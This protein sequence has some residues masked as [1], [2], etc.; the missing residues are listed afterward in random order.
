[1]ADHP[2][3]AAKV[4]IGWDPRETGAYSVA[5]DSLL[6]NSSIP[7]AVTPLQLSRLELG[8]LVRRPR[9]ML[10]KGRQ[11]RVTD[12]R[13]ERRW[14]T[15]AQ[16][17]T[18]IDEISDAPMSTEFACSRFIVPLL[19]QSGWALFVDCDVLFLAD[20]R[21][22]FALADD[23]F[24]VMVVQHGELAG[25]GFKM[26]G[27]P[28]VPYRRKNWSSVMLF[29]CDHPANRRLTLDVV[30]AVPGRDL[31]AFAWLDA[32]LI[33]ALPGEWNWLVGVQPRPASPKLAH[34]TLGGPWL[35]SWKGAEHDD[36]WLSAAAGAG[37]GAG[38]GDAGR[39]EAASAHR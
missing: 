19:A 4:Y 18:M 20:V 34:Y 38:T 5:V 3:A 31:H 10:S 30:N 29:N 8:G 9:S 17:G 6:R 15:A 32:D 13:I 23:R 7:V 26:D 22:L 24:A 39:A 1:M 28:Q 35:P 37:A 2:N 25:G 11:L 21:E 33:G 14:V 36:L 27:Q 12:G 16:R